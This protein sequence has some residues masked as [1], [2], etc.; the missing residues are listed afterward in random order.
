MPA[1]FMFSKNSTARCTLRSTSRTTTE[2]TAS[3][4]P[5][6][7]PAG[8]HAA[9][10]GETCADGVATK[11]FRRSVRRGRNASPAQWAQKAMPF[12]MR[13]GKEHTGQSLTCPGAPATHLDRTKITDKPVWACGFDAA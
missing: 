12:I 10:S 11:N 3:G 2:A 13:L 8:M 5:W 6:N 7:R 1:V 4:D 9:H